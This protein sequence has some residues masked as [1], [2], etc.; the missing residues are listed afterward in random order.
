MRVVSIACDRC[1]RAVED[2]AGVLRL[3]GAGVLHP[4]T[5]IDLCPTCAARFVEWV[6][7]DD[8]VEPESARSCSNREVQAR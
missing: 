8:R 1:K 4:M 7:G 5:P 3:E 2:Q 6:Q